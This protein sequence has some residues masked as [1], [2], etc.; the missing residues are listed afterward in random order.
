MKIILKVCSNCLSLKRR[1]KQFCCRN[2]KTPVNFINNPEEFGCIFFNPNK[3]LEICEFCDRTGAFFSGEE[4][5]NTNNWLMCDRC[6]GEGYI[7]T[8]KTK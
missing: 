7:C 8:N 1:Q 2:E 6:N 3:D 4:I 5:E